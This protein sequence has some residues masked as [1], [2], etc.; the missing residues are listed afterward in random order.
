MKQPEPFL[1]LKNSPYTRWALIATI[2]L[3][4]I[5]HISSFASVDEKIES[6][7]TDEE[8]QWL[9]EH[10]D[11]TFY[12]G[13]DPD[14]GMEYFVYRDLEM[15]YLND[16]VNMLSEKI[17]LNLQIRPELS[18][19]EAVA[20]LNSGEIQILFGANP[21][22]E[23]LKTMRFTDEIYSVP[24]TVLGR[25]LGEVQTIGDLNTR[26]V[27]FLEGDIA[28][29]LFPEA[30]P[31]LTYD[32]TYY[33]TQDLAL[34]ALNRGQI[35]GF[36][37]SGG[38]VVYDYLFRYPS[39]RVVA[40]IED[41]RS[42]MTFS[43]LIE[44]E[45]L[46][47]I[48][49]KSFTACEFDIKALIDEART[50]FVRK[51]LNLT[52][53]ELEWLYAH[54][55]IKVGVPT[56]YLPIDYPSGEAYKGIAGHYLTAFSQ[57][58]G[59][60]LEVVEGTFDDVYDMI[61]AREIDVLN[62]A[63]TD[64]RMNHFVF[65]EPFSNERDLIYGL[66][67]SPYVHDIYGLE[68]KNVAVINGF[69]HIDYLK[70]NLRDVNLVLT[71]DIQGAI[72]A[73]VTGKADYFIETPAVAEFYISGLGY[74]DIIK[75]GATSSDSFL[76]F[77]MLPEHAPL[78]SLFNRARILISYEDAKYL[79]VQGLPEVTNVA[80]KRLVGVI[81][82]IS[83]FVLL[84]LA[85]L[86]KVL[87]DLW[88]TRER[89]RLIYIDPLTGLYNRGYFNLLESSAQDEPFPQALFVL[90]INLLKD[91]N[92]AYGHHQ[93]DRL[94]D[95]VSTILKD[96]AIQHHG[97]AI[98]MGGDEFVLLFFGMSDY[99][100]HDVADSLRKT[101]EATPLMDDE[102]IIL[103]QLQVAIGLGTRVNA[104]TPF[105]DL[106]KLADHQMYQNKA[107]MKQNG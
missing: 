96:I 59:L 94:I 29:T 81:V 76:T 27:G 103:P 49:S 11:Q 41:I 52:H 21:T 74:T 7:L 57:L 53:D 16:I 56:D 65:T 58:I 8:V 13:L 61:Q 18:W 72:E 1:S 19:S 2:I 28:S 101:L 22:P 32:I 75:K 55:K 64:D 90:D 89:E 69:W 20:G 39:L 45:M 50:H 80:N 30:Y 99:I 88:L 97:T 79:G 68:G 86:M 92:D 9:D 95:A 102:K 42:M 38:D 51:I 85:T 60:E 62:M 44:N 5:T 26:R 54:P 91:V 105:E 63:K 25:V 66:S 71:K 87:R 14:A 46:V 48:L 73:V 82:A 83:L 10:A 6:L 70:L 98:R 4:M 40:N 104:N 23:R 3:L 93:G 100:A 84:L 37:T 33:E 24:Y 67:N 15:G 43:T 106:F 34:I 36:I 17:G 35:D 77:G 107:K 78:A 12:V 31:N 47:S